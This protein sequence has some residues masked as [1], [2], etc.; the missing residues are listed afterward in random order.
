MS[1]KFSEFKTKK[2]KKSLTWTRTKIVCTIGPASGSS[3]ILEKMA[4]AGMNVARLNFSHG[5]HDEHL[6]Y[7]KRIRAV[8]EKLEKPIAILQDLPGPRIRVGRLNGRV[9]AL[10]KGTNIILTTQTEKHNSTHIPVNY[11]NIVKEVKRGDVIFLSDGTIKLKVLDVTGS[12]VVCH[13]LTGGNLVSGKGVNIPGRQ[14]DISL[15]TEEDI[16]HLNFG[17]KQDV[18]FVALSFVRSKNDIEY[19]RNL[20][21]DAGASVQI[22]AKIEKQEAVRNIDQIISSADGVMIARGDLGV[23]VGVEVVP[24]IQKEIIDKC[25]RAGKPVITATQML[26]SMVNNPSPT[27]AEVA[28]VANAIFD[29]TDGVMLSEETAIGKYPVEAVSM[30]SKISFTVEKELPYGQILSARKASLQPV[31]E[32][33]ISYAACQIALDL[34]A[35]AIVSF[36]RS[37]STARRI[38]R[39][40]TPSPIIALTPNEKILNQL[41]LSWGVYPFMTEKRNETSSLFVEAER[42]VLDESLAKIGDKIIIVAGDPAGPEGTTNMLKVHTI[43]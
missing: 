13:V 6:K 25:N 8:S 21:S 40:R 28:D 2:L 14:L 35:I 18:D 32:D 37:G 10:K 5:T 1:R 29:G 33:A 22:I 20:I 23:E 38:S 41:V 27:R 17:L 36:T 4:N 3:K 43:S 31:P 7:I 39:Y 19:V 16:R 11:K 26:D 42:K 34:H 9:L 12:E 24:L 30:L 15:F